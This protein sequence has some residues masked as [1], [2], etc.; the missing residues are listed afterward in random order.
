VHDQG[1][2]TGS[3][4]LCAYEGEEGWRVICFVP[5]AGS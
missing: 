2:P 1:N 4:I 3:P 5:G